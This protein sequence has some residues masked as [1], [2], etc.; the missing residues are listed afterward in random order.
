MCTLQADVEQ[1]LE[2]LEIPE[3]AKLFHLEGYKTGE[4][5]ENLK[6]L[7]EKDLRALGILK[8][9]ICWIYY[10]LNFMMCHVAHFPSAHLQRLKTG[11]DNLIKPTPCELNY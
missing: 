1:W 3:Y 7:K 5:I 9:G 8:R 4:D 11:I 2:R 6:D 10:D